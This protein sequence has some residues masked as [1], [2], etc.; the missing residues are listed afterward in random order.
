MYL[1]WAGPWEPYSRKSIS[2][3]HVGLTATSVSHSHTTGTLTATQEPNT[4]SVVP[5]TNSPSLPFP[6]PAT[7]A[8]QVPNTYENKLT[9]LH[10][11]LLDYLQHCLYILYTSSELR[12]PLKSLQV[13]VQDC[14]VQQ[15]RQLFRMDEWRLPRVWPAQGGLATVYDVTS[16][17]CCYDLCSYYS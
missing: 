9:P 5:P 17:S 6:H 4:T 13:D 14:C 7:H 15:T 11:V 8:K 2:H 3:V 16:C 1:G 12:E 10:L